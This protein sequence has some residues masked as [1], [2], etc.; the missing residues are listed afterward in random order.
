[1]DYVAPTVVATTPLDQ[2]KGVVKN[3]MISI[4]FSEPMD[5]DSVIQ[6]Y[7]SDELRPDNAAFAWEDHNTRLVI[8]PVMPLDYAEV[9]GVDQPAKTFT[10]TIG[11]SAKDLAGNA[12]GEDWS[13]SFSTLRQISQQIPL[14]RGRRLQHNP[15]ADDV[16][17]HGCLLGE[18]LI[19]GDNA[20]DAT[21]AMVL[22]YDTAGLAEGIVDW[23]SA[24]IE[25][26]FTMPT[27]DP[28]GD[29]NLGDLRG[30]SVH[31]KVTELIWT[32]PA[33]YIGVA[34]Q[35]DSGQHISLNVLGELE[36]YYA[37][38]DEFGFEVLFKFALDTNADGVAQYIMPECNT[39]L[40]VVYLAP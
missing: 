16:G 20:S 32:T 38:P 19:V 26:A 11:S 28:F 2:A 34:A 37:A 13:F 8:R 33:S 39:S 14:M 4:T 3:A 17:T 9:T 24:S 21:W 27:P 10:I 36:D 6:V 15:G 35:E 7:R 5:V 18:D 1:V 23:N 25:G 31:A 29:G 12:L 40:D 22:I 30:Y